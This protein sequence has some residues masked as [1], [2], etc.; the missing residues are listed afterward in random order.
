MSKQ[1]RRHS[2]GFKFQVALDAQAIKELASHYGVHLMESKPCYRTV[3]ACF[4]PANARL[5][6]E[7]AVL[8]AE[9]YEQLGGSRWNWSG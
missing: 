7:Q 2:A 8:Q 6:R 4:F 3:P 5:Q 9:L 1:R